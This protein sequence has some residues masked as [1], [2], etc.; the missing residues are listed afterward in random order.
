MSR[1]LLEIKFQLYAKPKRSSEQLNSSAR[2]SIGRLPQVTRILALAVHFEEMI[3]KGDAQDY[4]DIGRLCCL[5]RERVSQVTRLNYLAPDIQVELLYLPPTLTGRYPI[6]ESAVR[7]I[8]NLLSWAD[9]RAAWTELKR[10]HH[11]SV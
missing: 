3:R 6:S 11:L 7:K 9:Q 8:A 10:Q 1:A 2:A 5:C 4:A